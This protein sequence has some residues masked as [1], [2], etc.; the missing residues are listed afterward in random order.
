MGFGR[1]R[2]VLVIGVVVKNM[3]FH[4][5]RIQKLELTVWALMN[6]DFVLHAPVIA[7]SGGSRLRTK[8]PE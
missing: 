7:R 6:D 5:T 1:G 3:V 2:H 4:F 8:A